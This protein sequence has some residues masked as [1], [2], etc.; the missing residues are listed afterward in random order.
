MQRTFV[1][2]ICVV[3][4]G[5]LQ[6]CGAG[7]NGG[8]TPT[9]F[10]FAAGPADLS[11]SPPSHAAKAPGNQQKFNAYAG[12]LSGP[13]CATPQVMGPV[14][15]TW[16]TSQPA[17]VQISSAKDA[18]NGLVTCVGATNGAATLTASYTQDGI[19]ETATTS[20]SCQ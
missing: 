4:L 9:A 12:A 11:A 19:T 3:S 2:V 5:A 18:T 7:V 14:Q 15:A 17:V 6:G 1:G 20:V 13:G 8:C 16:T 10:S